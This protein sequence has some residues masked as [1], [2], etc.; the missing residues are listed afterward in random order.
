M[1]MNCPECGKPFGPTGVRV[2][3]ITGRIV[4]E[5][6]RDDLLAAA[7]G[8]IAHPQAPIPGAI[9]TQGWFRR[10]RLRKQS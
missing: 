4:C 3:T 8:V 2:Q 9:E 1:I 6:C 5:Q 7:A 10:L